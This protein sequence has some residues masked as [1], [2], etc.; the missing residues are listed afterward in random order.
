MGELGWVVPV[1]VLVNSL[2]FIAK[3]VKKDYL[4]IEEWSKEYESIISSARNRKSDCTPKEKEDKPMVSINHNQQGV[5]P[6]GVFSNKNLI[7]ID[8]TIERNLSEAI[9]YLPNKG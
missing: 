2:Y 3:S 9:P 7:E 5:R 4:E 8:F 6:A 1:I